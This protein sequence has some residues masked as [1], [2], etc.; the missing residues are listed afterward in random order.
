MPS[1][2]SSTVQTR[3]SA[4]GRSGTM[5]FEHY[6]VNY[7]RRQGPPAG[8]L[9]LQG[10][11]SNRLLLSPRLPPSFCMMD[12]SVLRKRFVFFPTAP[13]SG[14]ASRWFSDGAQAASARR[15][16]REALQQGLVFALRHPL[17]QT[18]DQLT[19]PTRNP[20]A[21]K[22]ELTWWATEPAPQSIG[23]QHSTYCGAADSEA[24]P[25]SLELRGWARI[26]AGC[27]A[28]NPSC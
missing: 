24:K 6:S 15:L 10:E 14:F 3:L 16:C 2:I 23:T 25:G 26:S 13:L 18:T 21:R 8:A 7:S 12:A 19:I 5:A 4:P 20:A 17:L 27:R 11:R 9:P 22:F 28:P 1:P